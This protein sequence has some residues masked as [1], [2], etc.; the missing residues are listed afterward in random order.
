MGLDTS[1][2]KVAA[3]YN[4]KVGKKGHYHHEHTIIPKVLEILQLDKGSTLLDLACGQGVLARN[5][6]AIKKYVGVDSAP[7]LLAE[8]KKFRYPFAAEFVQSD[9]SKPLKLG[10]FSRV[11]MILALQNVAEPA[12][13]FKNIEQSL[14]PGG[15]AVI[16]LNH[17][18]LRIP[19]QTS[20][21]IDARN[22]IQYRRVNRYLSP[23]KVPIDMTP[24]Q[25]KQKLT[26]SFHFPIS[27]Y[28]D[29]AKKSG[30]YV[31]DL[32]EWVSDKVSEGKAARMENLARQEFPLFMTLVL[33]KPL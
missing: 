32:Q 31:T 6:P 5:V 21:E 20:W 26:W 28:F 19:R 11:A 12:G 23:L 29:L 25:G 27:Y 13:V 1:W 9:V 3:A 7:S 17:P 14:E 8:A 33:K 2:Q 18:V 4:Q 16:V 30:L 10:K 24:G 15:E 22:K